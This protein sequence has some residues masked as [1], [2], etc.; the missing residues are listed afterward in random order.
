MIDR[1]HFPAI[2]K[3]AR[4]ALESLDKLIRAKRDSKAK[5][6]LWT[7]ELLHEF[8]VQ[9]CAF[10]HQLIDAGCF[11]QHR[12]TVFPLEGP[13]HALLL[14]VAEDVGVDDRRLPQEIEVF[15]ARLAELVEALKVICRPTRRR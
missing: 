2:A 11:D 7:D 4:T 1:K 6:I 15:A 10:R 14:T 13:A 12:I 3:S 5:A 9:L 8:M